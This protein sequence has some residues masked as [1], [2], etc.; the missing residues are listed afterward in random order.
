MGEDHISKL[1]SKEYKKQFIV[2]NLK[3]DIERYAIHD[4]KIVEC[5]YDKNYHEKIK[6]IR[7]FLDEEGYVYT[8]KE[9]YN[10]H[11]GFTECIFIIDIEQS[12][13]N[14]KQRYVKKKS[15]DIG[16]NL[17]PIVEKIHQCITNDI[18]VLSINCV[19]AEQSKK[20]KDCIEK[21]FDNIIYVE[22]DYGL[23]LIF[24]NVDKRDVYNVV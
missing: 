9:E 2:S 13:I 11:L 8:Q 21:I 24:V 20:F 19:D 15:N 10:K 23:D 12:V 5:R 22:K 14:H 16:I 1:Y 6:I 18:K 3:K 17:L 4:M 7:E